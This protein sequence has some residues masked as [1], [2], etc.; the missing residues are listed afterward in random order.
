MTAGAIFAALA[1]TAGIGRLTAPG[2]R[3]Q[4]VVATP[5]RTP[6]FEY[7]AHTAPTGGLTTATAVILAL[8]IVGAA[9]IGLVFFG[10]KT[11]RRPR[12]SEA[13]ATRCVTPGYPGTRYSSS[14][15]GAVLET[16]IRNSRLF[17]VFFKRS[18][19]RSMD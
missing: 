5:A 12:R 15:P 8:L 3:T 13:A 10:P 6:Q 18:I 9:V 16:V 7:T 11:V 4:L 19:S 17:L 1:L 2:G 14:A